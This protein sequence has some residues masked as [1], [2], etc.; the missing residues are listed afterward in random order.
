[1]PIDT[2]DVLQ[3]ASSRQYV[4]A[5]RD[6]A[7][8][9]VLAPLLLEEPGLESHTAFIG[10]LRREHPR[11]AGFWSLLGESLGVPTLPTLPRSVH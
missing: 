6:M 7:A 2:E 3:R 9:V 8:C 11:K 5:A 1:M 4:Y 10:R